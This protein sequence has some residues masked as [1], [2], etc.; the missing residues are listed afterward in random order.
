MLVS[1]YLD[2]MFGCYVCLSVSDI[3]MGIF[4]DVL[5]WIFEL[6]FIIK[7]FGKGMGLGF[8]MVFGIVK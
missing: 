2:V 3:G 1:I 7:G 8:V 4:L 5:F 6:F